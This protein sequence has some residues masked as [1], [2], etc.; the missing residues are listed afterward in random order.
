MAYDWFVPTNGNGI[1]KLALEWKS[2]GSIFL[3]YVQFKL[4]IGINGPKDQLSGRLPD[5][6]LAGVALELRTT[7]YNNVPVEI[8]NKTIGFRILIKSFEFSTRNT[9]I[10]TNTGTVS[11]Y[12]IRQT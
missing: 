3:V 8:N 12:S 1:E 4:A 6:K 9:I 10:L 11:I 5:W 2:T 7:H